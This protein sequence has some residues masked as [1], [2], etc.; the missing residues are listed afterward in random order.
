M[1]PVEREAVMSLVVIPGGR[2]AADPANVLRVFGTDDGV[3]LGARLL[4]EALEAEDMVEVEMA[5]VVTSVF[6]LSSDHLQPLI[7]LAGADWHRKHEDVVSM[8][9]DMGDPAAV[10]VLARAT[11]WVPDYLEHDEFRRLAVNA[12]WA[13]GAIPGRAAERELARVAETGAEKVRGRAAQQLARR[14]HS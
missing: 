4:R 6:G 2:T 8:L 1:T 10:E 14:E 7:A 13:L 11:W 3:K 12:V 9:G 5:I